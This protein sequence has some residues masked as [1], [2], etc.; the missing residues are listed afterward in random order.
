MVTAI[1]R[2]CKSPQRAGVSLV[3]NSGQHEVVHPGEVSSGSQERRS[4]VVVD[5]VLFEHLGLLG[6]PALVEELFEPP[7]FY[8]RRLIRPS[9]R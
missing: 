4:P 2:I 5:A 3:E 6:R 8:A 7:R 9:G 1:V